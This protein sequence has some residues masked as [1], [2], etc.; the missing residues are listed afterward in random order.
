MMLAARRVRRQAHSLQ[1]ALSC[2]CN[3]DPTKFSGA[4]PAQAFNLGEQR[5]ETF[6]AIC[7]E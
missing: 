2:W 3:S 7:V 4:S 1:C 6:T 5:R